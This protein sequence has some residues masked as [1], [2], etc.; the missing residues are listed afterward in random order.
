[1]SHADL[2]ARGYAA[3]RDNDHQAAL[4][5]FTQAAAIDPHDIRARLEMAAELLALGRFDAAEAVYRA[6]LAGEPTQL[7]ALL[8][9]GRCARRVGDREVALAHFQ[10]AMAAHPQNASAQMESANELLALGRFDAAEAVYRAML[11]GEPTQLQALLGLGRCARRVGDREV[12]LAHFQAA[13]AAYPHDVW[14]PLEIAAELRDRGDFAAAVAACEEV[15]SEHPAELQAWLSIG[16]TYHRAGQPE[17]ALVAFQ[18]AAAQ[19]NA[20]V[21][22]RIEAARLQRHL[23]Q[24]AASRQTLHDLL[25]M[26]PDQADALQEMGA[27]ARLSENLDAA[28]ALFRR[29]LEA[30]PLNTAAAFGLSQTLLELGKVDEALQLLTEFAERSNAPSEISVKQI[31]ILR[32]IGKWDQA[33]RVVRVAS[34][35]TPRHFWLWYQ[36]VE[37]EILTANYDAAAKELRQPPTGNTHEWARVYRLRGLLAELQWQFDTAVDHYRQAQVL[38]PRDGGLCTDLARVLLLTLDVHGAR[39]QLQRLAKLNSPVASLQGRSSN[40]SQT[41]YGQIL[42]EYALDAETLGEMVEL[43]K[44]PASERLA[45]L[46]DLVCRVPDYTP[47][48]IAWLVALRQAGRLPPSVAVK[49]TGNVRRISRSIAQYWNSPEPPADVCALM[50]SWRDTN[51]DYEYRLFDDPAAREFLGIYPPEVRRA[52]RRAREPAQKADIFRLAWLFAHGGYYVDADD[53]CLEPIEAH[54]PAHVAL[55]GYQEDVGSIGNN[56]IGAAPQHSVIGRALELAVE[57]VNRG[58]QDLLWFSTGP[59]LLTRAFVQTL[60]NSKLDYSVWLAG[61]LLLGRAQIH[62]MTV[63]HCLTAY[64][65]T[66]RHWN[67]SVFGRVRS[68]AATVPGNGG[69]PR[70]DAGDLAAGA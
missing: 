43:G 64:K 2:L 34:D 46:L 15:L 41:L 25:Q 37:M 10:A 60:A 36:R 61:V 27:Q 3:R 55:V 9:L 1:V 32:R 47:A 45:P 50:Q 8:G 35:S 22:P 11:A 20:A 28:E 53:R 24:F 23:G 26:V 39:E 67:K 68:R 13:M 38:N 54:I 58:D 19:A 40:V 51:P 12:A 63:P 70:T 66:R 65:Q 30:Q 29:A 49:P 57:A 69:S 7:Q 56:F 33:L 31:E 62:R 14:P 16:R 48:A 18:N 52:Y 44:L 4:D 5:L 6:M 59:G 21:Q 42:D 17:L